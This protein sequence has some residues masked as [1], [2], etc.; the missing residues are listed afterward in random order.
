MRRHIADLEKRLEHSERTGRLLSGETHPARV[1]KQLGER[2][3]TERIYQDLVEEQLLDGKSIP[4][5]QEARGHNSQPMESGGKSIG[6]SALSSGTQEGSV[7]YSGSTWTAVTTNVELVK[8]LHSLYFSWEH[9][10][11]PLF[12]KNHFITDRESG[13]QR[14]CSP[15][16]VNVIAALGC[17]FSGRSEIKRDFDTGAKF[18]LEAERIWEMEQSDVSITYIQA[19]ALMS[20]WEASQG[21]HN[22]GAFYSRQALSMAVEEGLHKKSALGASEEQVRIATFGASS[23]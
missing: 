8:Q 15:L 1:S 7:Y 4:R 16:L 9:A 13:R 10:D 20:L 2:D 5:S 18:Y 23:H 19:T 11:Y 3:R 17:K 12:S 14:Y 22:R 21:R 6:E